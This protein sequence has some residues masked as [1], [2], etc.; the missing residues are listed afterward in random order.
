MDKRT[1]KITFVT[2]LWQGWR[3]GTYCRKHVTALRNM[4]LEHAPEH[5]LCLVTDRASEISRYLPDDVLVYPMW[6]HPLEYLRLPRNCFARLKLFDP[7][8]GPRFGPRLV[9]IDLDVF[10]QKGF[11]ELFTDT[12]LFRAVKGESSFFNGSMWEMRPGAYPDVWN[13]FIRDPEDAKRR[14]SNSK[15][16]GSDQAWLSL[17]LRHV[18]R[19]WDDSDG[20]MHWSQKKYIDVRHQ[21]LDARMVCFAGADKPWSPECKRLMPEIHRRYM[22]YYSD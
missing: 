14:I 21:L 6:E 18:G 5:R 9:S 16:Y 7:E 8:F 3:P 1:D 4:L 19:V 20:V 2:W 17:C 11:A 22:E 10:I 12:P 15:F 13:D